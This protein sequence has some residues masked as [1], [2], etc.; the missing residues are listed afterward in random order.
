MRKGHV[1]GLNLFLAENLWKNRH[2]RFKFKYTQDVMII[3]HGK[4]EKRVTAL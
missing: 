3:V 2:A 4:M 1:A